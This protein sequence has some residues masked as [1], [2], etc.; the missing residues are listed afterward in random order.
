MQTCI[1]DSSLPSLTVPLGSEYIIN[2]VGL[3][4]SLKRLQMHEAEHEYDTLT[5]R[6]TNLHTC[7]QWI[8]FTIVEW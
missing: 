3:C 6:G 7:P 2:G 8:S 5:Q 1:Q 4:L